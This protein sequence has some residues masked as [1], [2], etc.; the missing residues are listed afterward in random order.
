VERPSGLTW[1]HERELL[2][3]SIVVPRRTASEKG[4]DACGS[5][6]DQ[7]DGGAAVAEACELIVEVQP[8]SL[9]PVG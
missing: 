4:T 5:H 2:V 3:A 7:P 1:G 8:L 6:A 9:R